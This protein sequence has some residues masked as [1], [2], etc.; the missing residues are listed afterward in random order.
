VKVAF[1]ENIPPRMVRLFNEDAGLSG[2]CEIVS[3]GDYRPVDE[4]GDDNWIRRFAADGGNVIITGDT[5]IRARVHE[6]AAL[7]QTGLISYYFGRPWNTVKFEQKTEELIAKFPS[8]IAH[9]QR[10][11]PGT[12]WEIRFGRAVGFKDVS[13]LPEQL[14]GK[15]KPRK[16]RKSKP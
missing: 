11:S 13:A 8:I 9:A 1:D 12:C 6:R 16:K 4:R 2:G 10:A 5:R 7:A 15:R 3:A 14:S